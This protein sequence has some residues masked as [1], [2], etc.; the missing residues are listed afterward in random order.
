MPLSDFPVDEMTTAFQLSADQNWK[1]ILCIYMVGVR[2]LSA[3]ECVKNLGY[4]K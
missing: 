2:S 3:L 4:T 1:M